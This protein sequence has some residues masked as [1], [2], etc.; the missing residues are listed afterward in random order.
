MN[1]CPKCG[2]EVNS[3][4]V[5]CNHCGA[6]MKV[7]AVDSV[8]MAAHKKEI[9]EAKTEAAKDAKNRVKEIQAR[10]RKFNLPADF[11]NAL[12]DSDDTVEECIVKI[13]DKIDLATIPPYVKMGKDDTEKFRSLVGTSLKIAS[14]LEKDGK[15]IADI[16]AQGSPTTLHATIR[17]CL[18][19]EGKLNP[20]KID[21]LTAHDLALQGLRLA[22]M[23]I[24]EGTSDFPAILADVANKA[25]E[26]GMVEEE[27]TYQKWCGEGET[28]DFKT[29]NLVKLSNFGDLKTIGEGDNFERGRFSDKKETVAI[30]TKG[31]M[32]NLSRQA[33][34]ND[35]LNAFVMVPRA[36]VGAA[37]RGINTDVYDALASP[38]TGPIMAEGGGSIHLFDFSNHANILTG[39]GAT[40]PTIASLG[41]M[42]KLLREI[43]MLAPE[44][45]AK[46]QYTNAEAKYLITGTVNETIAQQLLLPVPTGNVIAATTPT[47]INPFIGTL[48]PVI[49]PYLGALLSTG[50]KANAWYLAA[51]QTRIPTF[52]IYYLQGNRVPTIRNQP[53]EVGEALGIAWDIYFDWGIGL[54]DWRGLV[55]CDGATA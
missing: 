36:M 31:R 35:D 41:L 5:C 54:A 15:V 28:K 12:I 17:A 34:V 52:M 13:V 37:Q 19:Q 44:K 6:Q 21:N 43:K 45:S 10:C 24:N 55:Y 42:R 9:E 18:R 22:K 46:T 1:K 20:N 33:I 14:G 4:F 48:Q 53:S 38:L 11:E 26:T 30:T 51:S 40:V 49:D 2:K 16:R 32:F 39:T 23:S 3:E 29:L 8:L 25:L 50:G 7:S 47:S 27:T